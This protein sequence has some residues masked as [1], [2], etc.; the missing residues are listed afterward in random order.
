MLQEFQEQLSDF[1]GLIPARSFADGCTFLWFVAVAIG[2]QHD[3]HTS[4]AS[5]T[6]NAVA[7]CFENS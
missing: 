3:S 2:P 1:V 5:I 7:S 4:V 6:S